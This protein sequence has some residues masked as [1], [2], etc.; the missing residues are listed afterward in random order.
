VPGSTFPLLLLLLLLVAS[1]N[2]AKPKKTRICKITA[3]D[4]LLS[5][6]IGKL[7]GTTARE[8]TSK[9]LVRDNFLVK[10]T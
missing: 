7:K 9:F 1:P 10:Q 8:V 5:E 4:D 6:A 2:F 3:A